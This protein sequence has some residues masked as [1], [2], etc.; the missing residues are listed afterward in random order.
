MTGFTSAMI[1]FDKDID[2][3]GRRTQPKFYGYIP[4]DN[5]QRGRCFILMT[6]LSA[7]HNV[8]RS[9]GVALLAASSNNMLVVYFVD[10]E[11]TLYFMY[12]CLRGDI[13]YWQRAEGIQKYTNVFFCRLIGK[14]I[15][16]FS[17]CLHMK[18]PYELGGIV[19]SAS[20][21][22]VQIMPFVAFYS[23]RVATKTLSRQSW[24][25]AP[26]CGFS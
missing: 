23:S 10:G 9:L 15:A 26:H 25:A 18:H 19:F 17:G 11:I 20:M 14:V 7:L 24:L 5:G 6:I 1:A 16:D 13:W 21:V 4:D 8:S 2:V 12:K 22:W 3:A